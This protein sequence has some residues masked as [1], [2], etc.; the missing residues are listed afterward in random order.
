MDY[1]QRALA[2]EEAALAS[3]QDRPS[4]P[5]I[6]ENLAIIH[7]H[8]GDAAKALGDLGKA[9]YH[10]QRAVELDPENATFSDK[11]KSLVPPVT[12]APVRTE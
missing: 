2:A 5:E 8:A 4:R 6:E 12:E 1:I 9:R 7:D 11:L 3:A 10:W